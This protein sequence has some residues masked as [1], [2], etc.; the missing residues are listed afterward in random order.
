MVVFPR[1]YVS[2]AHARRS[3]CV[4]MQ[5]HLGARGPVRP[6]AGSEP[7][8]LGG[9]GILPCCLEAWEGPRSGG[10]HWG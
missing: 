5:V 8:G 6:P 2:D 10:A 7:V 3:V 1:L 4:R 9:C